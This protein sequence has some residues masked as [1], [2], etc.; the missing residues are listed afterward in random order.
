ML[1]GLLALITKVNYKKFSARAKE[2]AVR[3]NMHVLQKGVEAFAIDHNGH[4]P[5]SKDATKLMIKLPDKRYPVNPYTEKTTTVAWNEDPEDSGN[6]SI[7]NI[8]DETYLI[9][10]RGNKRFLTPDLTNEE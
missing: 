4:Y 10:G 1:I 5:Q 8:S 9:R 6:I 3:E 7:F 2:A